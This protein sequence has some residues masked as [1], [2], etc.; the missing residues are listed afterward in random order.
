MVAECFWDRQGAQYGDT[1]WDGRLTGINQLKW[2]SLGF[3][4]R[5]SHLPGGR[6]SIPQE[7]RTGEG[8]EKLAQ[9]LL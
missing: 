8:F 9:S 2:M 3:R 5:S 7:G 6:H 4:R 1:G